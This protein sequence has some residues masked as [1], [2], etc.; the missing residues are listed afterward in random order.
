M[1]YRCPRCWG[2]RKVVHETGAMAQKSSVYCDDC[3]TVEMV[4]VFAG[5]VEEFL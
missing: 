3:I 2:K 1:R 4:P 5:D